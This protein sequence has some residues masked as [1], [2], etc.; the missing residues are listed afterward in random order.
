M[1]I[2]TALSKSSVQLY[3]LILLDRGRGVPALLG[4]GDNNECITTIPYWWATS[5]QDD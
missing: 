5:V 3:N 2:G 4:K 1:A